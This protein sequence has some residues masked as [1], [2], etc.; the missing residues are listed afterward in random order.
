[1][2]IRADICFRLQPRSM[3]VVHEKTLLNHTYYT[4]RYNVRAFN[5]IVCKTHAFA[6][7]SEL[8]T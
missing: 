7:T 6:S 1:M 4:R 3:F 8:R 5:C 2:S